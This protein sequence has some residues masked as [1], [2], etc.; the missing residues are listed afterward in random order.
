MLDHFGWL[1]PFYER[2]IPP[3]KLALWQK[4]LRLSDDGPNGRSRNG[5][6]LDIG[7]GTG[8]VSAQL[9]PYVAS[10]V[11]SDESLK[12]LAEA[13]KKE[14]CCALN[15]TAERL[16][17]AADSFARI[18][19]VDALH[20]FADQRLAVAEMARVLQ[21][22]GR[23]VIEEP[24]LNLF[25]VKALALAEKV[26]LMRSKFYSPEAIAEMVAALGLTAV[27]ERDGRFAAW[28][29]VDKP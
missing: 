21:P 11:I 8:R 12:M 27:I 14:V 15:S 4:L 9:R 10:L 16:P 17:F 18:M 19:V 13:Q 23:L 25:T 28:I 22:G 6:L 2:A 5:R 3:P 24:D 1:A 20:H 26:A 7:G 29:I